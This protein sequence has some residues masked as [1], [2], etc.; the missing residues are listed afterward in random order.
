MTA[1]AAARRGAR[2]VLLERLAALG[3][4]LTAGLVNPMLTFHAK[5]GRQVVKGLAPGAGRPPGARRRFARAR[6]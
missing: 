4:N 3:G 1:V 2:V 5:S 6:A